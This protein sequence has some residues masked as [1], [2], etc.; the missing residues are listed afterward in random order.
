[1]KRIGK[2]DKNLQFEDLLNKV[3]LIGITEVHNGELVQETQYNGTVVFAKENKKIEILLDDGSKYSIPPQLNNVMRARKGLYVEQ[4]SGLTIANPDFIS[5]WVIET[6]DYKR[7]PER[8]MVENSNLLK[9]E[10]EFVT[11]DYDSM[12]EKYDLKQAIINN[13]YDNRENIVFEDDFYEKVQT[14]DDELRKLESYIYR[15]ILMIKGESIVGYVVYRDMVYYN[16]LIILDYFLEDGFKTYD[17]FK[18]LLDEF[19]NLKKA[20][21]LCSLIEYKNN[22]YFLKYGFN[23]SNIEIYK[24]LPLYVYHQDIEDVVYKYRKLIRKEDNIADSYLKICLYNQKKYSILI[25]TVI[26]SVF[27]LFSFSLPLI[28][29][30]VTEKRFSLILLIFVIIFLITSIT[31]IALFNMHKIFVYEVMKK[32]ILFKD[33]TFRV[34]NIM[35][36]L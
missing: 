19:R 21:E 23:K 36:F 2:I 5:T 1:M 12:N 35:K 31:S 29:I 6:N 18:L 22:D 25:L 15:Y 34:D 33:L 20:N 27:F 8:I 13:N 26:I 3:M 7:V 4:S 17:N 16:N 28:D 24:N 9:K 30:F 11:F 14:I 10:V 32:D